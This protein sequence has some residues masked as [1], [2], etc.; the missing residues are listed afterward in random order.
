MH[1]VGELDIQRRDDNADL[2]FRLGDQRLHH[3]FTSFEMTRWHVPSTILEAGVL[4]AA[5]QDL[6]VRAEQKQMNITGELVTAS[7]GVVAG[8]CGIGHEYFP[9]Y[10][11]IFATAIASWCNRRDYAS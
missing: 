9:E 5:E 7:A 2:L 4:T 6:A 11:L 3:R 1:Y 10:R 8:R